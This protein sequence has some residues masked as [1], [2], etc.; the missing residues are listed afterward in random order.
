MGD[1]HIRHLCKFFFCTT[2]QLTP[3]VAG[4]GLQHYTGKRIYD[5]GG[6]KVSIH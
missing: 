1:E 2:S 6:V 4:F 5:T 3:Y